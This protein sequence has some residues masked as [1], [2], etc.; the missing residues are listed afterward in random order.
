MTRFLLS[1]A[2]AV[3]LLEG[4]AYA[5]QCEDPATMSKAELEKAAQWIA[6]SADVIAE[7]ELPRPVDPAGRQGSVY[8]VIRPLIGNPGPEIF[9]APG[10]AMTSCDYAALPGRPVVMAFRAVRPQSG[11][12]PASGPCAAS[13]GQDSG[14]RPASMCTQYLTQSDGMI[15]RVRRILKLRKP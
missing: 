4:T 8:R 6:S 7:V 10:F 13:P 2:L 3:L 11:L 9:V 14:L 15:D 5:C 12:R 1:A